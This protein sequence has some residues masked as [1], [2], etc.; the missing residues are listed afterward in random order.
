[1]NRKHKAYL[2]L[3]VISLFF[4]AISSISV[5]LAWFAYSGIAKVSTE[6]EVKSWLI[7]FEKNKETVS[8]DI[9]ISLSEVYPGMETL[10][11]TI[12]IKNRGDSN[13]QLSASVISARILDEEIS[14]ENIEPNLILDKLSH[15]YPF[16]VNMSLD[17]N[18]IL[19]KGEE[20]AFNVSISWPLDS[21]NDELDSEWGNLAYQFGDNELKKL[22]EDS[23][24]SIRPSIKIIISV[25]AE[26]IT[27]SK[28]SSDINYPLGEMILYDINN[29][30]RCEELTETCIRT[31][32]IDINNK[33]GDTTVTLLPDILSSYPS[34]NYDNYD[35][36]LSTTV[37]KWNVNTRTLL[38]DDLL[39]IVSKDINNSF[40]IMEELS[41]SVIGYIENENRI[42]NI[43]TRITPYNGYFRFLN[44]KYMYLSTNKCY[45]LPKEY[46]KTKSFALTKNNEETSKIYGEDKNNNCSVI[47]VILAPKEKLQ[48]K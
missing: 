5:T 44:E 17:D 37:N 13:A 4:I 48:I 16:S 3:N 10:H 15:D 22:S 42:D 6:I 26:Q 11:E 33:K 20:S 12:K 9:V 45:W 47:P 38:L 35:E 23:T 28:E 41:D 31:H 18:F 25:K 8:N 21:D 39:K 43:I 34:G 29:D 19:A 1:M 40:I 32:V 24:Y 2:K 14:V 46:D 7:E 30:K 36:L 27:E